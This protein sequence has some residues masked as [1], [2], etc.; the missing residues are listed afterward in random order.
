MANYL[1]LKS[2]LVRFDLKV[3][4]VV[5]VRARVIVSPPNS[6]RQAFWARHHAKLIENLGPAALEQVDLLW[7]RVRCAADSDKAVPV[8]G[9]SPVKQA[10]PPHL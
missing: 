1:H 4:E 6:E 10:P 3:W 2:D 8:Q 5:L 7:G 9:L